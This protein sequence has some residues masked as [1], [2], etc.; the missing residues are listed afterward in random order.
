MIRRLGPALAGGMLGAIASVVPTSSSGAVPSGWQPP[1]EQY[2]LTVTEQN[3]EIPMSD[4]VSLK[5]DLTS[6]A[7]VAGQPVGGR[8]PVI[9]MVTPYNKTFIASDAGA[10]IAG[11]P[12]VFFAKHGYRYLVVDVRGT[13]ASPG[14]WQVFG[15]REQQDGAEVIEWVASQ[16]WSDGNVGMSGASAMGIAQLFTAGRRPSGLKAIAPNVPAADVYRDTA[17]SG[18]QIDVGFMPFWLTLVSTTGL[19]PTGGASPSTLVT[20]LQHLTGSAVP[21]ESLLLEGLAGGEMAYDGPWYRERSPITTAVPN[22]EV[23]TLLVAGHYDLFQR[24]APMVYQNLRDRGVPVKMILGPWDHVQGSGGGEVINAGYGALADLQLRWMDHYVRGVPDPDL[25]M[26]IPSFTYAEVGT[27]A[28]VKRSTYLDEQV[29]RSFALSGSTTTA[30]APARLTEGPVADGTGTV[31]PVAAAG[32][33]S[34]S[35]SQWTFGA[36][37]IVL[38]NSP[39]NSNNGVND[40]TGVVYESEPF[41]EDMRI[42]GPVNARLFVSSTTGDGLLSV[43]VSRVTPDGTVDRL[44]GGWQVM[45][46]AELDEAKSLTLPPYVGPNQPEPTTARAAIAASNAEIVQPWHPFTEESRRVLGPGEVTQADVEVFPIGARIKAGER[47]R[48]AVNAFDLPHL[49][50]TLDQLP[51]LGSVITIHNSTQYPSKLIVPTFQMA[52]AN[53]GSPPADGAAPVALEPRESDPPAETPRDW[54]ERDDDDDGDYDDGDEGRRQKRGSLPNA[55]SPV[56]LSSLLLAFAL[57][58]GGTSV[59]A[60]S[61]VRTGR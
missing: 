17:A 26:D 43:H 2:S 15:N 20:V 40:T 41:T 47:L 4:G 57:V 29:A 9:V 45:S 24:G 39:C 54:G 16:P 5:A 31:L 56:A 7:D 60:W 36:P 48:I 18:G 23:P 1:P 59:V 21:S 14:E 25:D 22:I 38:P 53:P 44:S 30:V 19:L 61:R 58:A 12:P 27:G 51:T 28:W 42:L 55:G 3:L 46:L 10:A 6:P 34:R 13:G 32:L 49:A 35:A 37:N 8:L 33:C 11:V 50:P 52:G